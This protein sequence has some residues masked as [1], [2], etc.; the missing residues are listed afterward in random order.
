M[1]KRKGCPNKTVNQ[2]TCPCTVAD[3]PRHGVCCECIEFHHKMGELTACE[4]QMRDMAA[5]PDTAPASATAAPPRGDDF[6]L[7]DYASCAG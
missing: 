1:A 2:E 4:T 7:T 6:R 3:C 5:A